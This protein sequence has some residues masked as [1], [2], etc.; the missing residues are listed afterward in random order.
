MVLRGDL[1]RILS[2]TLDTEWPILACESTSNFDLWDLNYDRRFGSPANAESL[3]AAYAAGMLTTRELQNGKYYWGFCLQG[4]VARWSSE[5]RLFFFRCWNDGWITRAIPHP[6]NQITAWTGTRT[7]GLDVFQP[8]REV[9]PLAFEIVDEHQTV[10]AIS[11]E[12]HQGR[13]Y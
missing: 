10:V 1:N 13:R 4:R 11:Q 9:D 3:S 12:Q 5:R 6:E 8:W 7:A 2:R